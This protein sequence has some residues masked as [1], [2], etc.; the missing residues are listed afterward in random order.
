MIT[1][2]VHC[3]SVRQNIVAISVTIWLY[4]IGKKSAN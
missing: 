4:A 3:P 2:E 1:G